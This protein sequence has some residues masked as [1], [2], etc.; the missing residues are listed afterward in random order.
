MKSHHKV[1]PD[2]EFFYCP[3][4]GEQDLYPREDRG[5]ECHQCQRAFTL[6]LTAT[7]LADRPHTIAPPT[8]QEPTLP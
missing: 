1:N 4:C 3:Y 8:R 6:T 7:R 2:M 5:W